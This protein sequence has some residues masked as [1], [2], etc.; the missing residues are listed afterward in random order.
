MNTHCD[1]QQR[2]YG[3]NENPYQS[4]GIHANSGKVWP[5]THDAEPIPE[6]DYRYEYK[7]VEQRVRRYELLNA[8]ILSGATHANIT[9]YQPQD[10]RNSGERIDVV[11]G[12]TVQITISGSVVNW[13]DDCV[14]GNDRRDDDKHDANKSLEGF[15]ANFSFS[16]IGY[17]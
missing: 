3:I 16:L 12:G 10:Y 13:F 4:S 6:E 14:D 15:H 1:I 2:E 7:P 11:P 8:R 9:E 5:D 17:S